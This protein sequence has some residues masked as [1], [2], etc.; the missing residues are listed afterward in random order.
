[1]T[2]ARW[3]VWGSSLAGLGVLCYCFPLFHVRRVGEMSIATETPSS[4]PADPIA[5][6][7]R[8]WNSPQ[9]RGE[10]ATEAN[11]LLDALDA[12]AVGAKAEFGN[13]VG[14]GG[15]W[16]FLVHGAGVVEQ[17]A[18]AQCTVRLSDSKRS[19]ELE[20]GVVVG[21]TVRDAIDVDVN[22]FAN[23]QNFNAVSAELNRLV[24]SKVIQPFRADLQVGV[25][26]KFVGCA[27][28]AKASDRRPLHIVPI[29]LEVDAVE[30]PTQE[31]PDGLR[32]EA[33]R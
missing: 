30:Q 13:Q 27:K 20:L 32:M 16:Y 6:V 28:I 3:I 26:V 12:D 21:N 9:R 25:T 14:L 1:M 19:V 8:F 33:E 31:L 23:S 11:H 22:N 2:R 5:F 24:E 29:W 7:H 17:V 4:Q 10:G 15:A 18:D